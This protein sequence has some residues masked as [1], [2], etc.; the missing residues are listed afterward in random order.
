[1]KCA[2]C[3]AENPEGAE[4][5]GSC[6]SPLAERAEAAPPEAPARPRRRRLSKMAIVSLLAACAAPWAGVIGDQAGGSWLP[7]D[8]TISLP[9]L[10]GLEILRYLLYIAAIALGGIAVVQVGLRSREL[11]GAAL[12]AGGIVLALGGMLG[13]TLGTYTPGR[14]GEFLSGLGGGAGEYDWLLTLVIFLAVILIEVA[15][16][17]VARPERPASA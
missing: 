3:G 16:S 1:M 8:P 6:S 7:A 14:P 2:K 11:R 17:L 10:L 9:V 5:C 12:A 15:L 13:A 4:V